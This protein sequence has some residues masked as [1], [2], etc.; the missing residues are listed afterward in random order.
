MIRYL[1]FV[2]LDTPN[3]AT[4]IFLEQLNSSVL[5]TLRKDQI[6]SATTGHQLILNQEGKLLLLMT[7]T[8]LYEYEG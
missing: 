7:M 5:H 4:K 2:S 6:V 8:V 1:Q 3:E